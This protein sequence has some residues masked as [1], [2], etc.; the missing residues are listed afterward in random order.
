MRPSER[1]MA[2]FDET[3]RKKLDRVPTHVQGVLDQFFT[4]NED[5]LLDDYDGELT[6]NLKFD[7]P[8]ILGFDAV[9]AGM[10]GS[11]Q[12]SGV[13]VEDKEGNRHHIGMSGQV[14]KKGSTFYNKGL[15]TSLENLNALWAT[16]KEVDH[17]KEIE[18]TV[19]F[20]ESISDKI[21]PVPMVGGIFDTMW[22]AMGM[23]DFSRNYRKKTKLY[24]EIIR[25][26]GENMITNIE[27]I[28]NATGGRGKVINILDDVAFKGRSMIPAKRWEEDLGPYYKK[29]CSII[30][31]AGMIPQIHTDGDV[32]EMIPS[33][34][35]VGFRGLQGWEGGMDP[36]YVNDH[37][38]DF[39]VVGFGDVSEVL[40]F[41]TLEEVDTHVKE[42]MDALK[43]NRHYIFGPSTVI[44]KEMPLKN[45][46][47]FMASAQKYGKYS[48]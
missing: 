23:K 17:S 38:P 8:Y 5:A 43:E 3:A 15:L 2:V 44:V 25:F 41:G 45:V 36:V 33:F 37:F 11:L 35:N 13:E 27:G 7:A 4:M 42:L 16:V 26:F 48:T 30:S 22:M 12:C 9:F 28:V 29:A 10:P 39:V 20:Y 47:Q 46:Q 1:Y 31:D 19:A 21:F 18:S 32:T 40:P 14:G 6:Y 24:T 34:Q